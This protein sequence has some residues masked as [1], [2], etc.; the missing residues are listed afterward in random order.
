[1]LPT[2]DTLCATA[3]MHG[4]FGAHL[5]V[6]N[7]TFHKLFSVSRDPYNIVRGNGLRILVDCRPRLAV[8][9]S[10]VGIRNGP[11]RLPLALSI[12]RTVTISVSARVSSQEPALQW[13][14]A[15][16]G[17]KKCRFLVFGH[18]VLGEQ[19]YASRGRLEIDARKKRFVFRPDPE[20]LWGQKYPL[21]SYRLVTSTPREVEAIGGDEWLYLDGERRGG[22]YAVMRT[23]PTRNFAFAV[24]GSLSDESQAKALAA[25]YA[26]KVDDSVMARQSAR[27]WRRI[28][29]D[30][31]LRNANAEATDIETILP[32][33]THDAMIHLTAPHGLEQYS[34]AAWGTRDVCQG[35]LELLLALE[36]DAPAKAD[37]TASS[38]PSNT[39]SA[40]TGRNGSCSSPTP[41]SRTGRRTGTSSSGR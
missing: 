11:L 15:V 10:A 41:P 23:R 32:W 30:V 14:I 6:G 37:L 22:G 28:T 3:W 19:D 38:S 12:W 40:A 1:M 17:G 24:V 8:A 27:A 39:K 36:H 4:V 2:D 5:T 7:T 21:A 34:V 18:L 33:L 16:E 9:V 35:P 25:K 20:S 31:R 26:A 29:R 13:R